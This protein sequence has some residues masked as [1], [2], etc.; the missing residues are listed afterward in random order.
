MKN[1][2]CLVVVLTLIVGLF[3][4]SCKKYEEDYGLM[5]KTPKGRL[6]GTWKI[7]Q[8][9]SDTIIKMSDFAMFG[10]LLMTFEKDESGNL[11]F[12]DN[13]LGDILSD[14]D[15]EELMSE[16]QDSTMNADSISEG[17]EN[18]DFSSMLSNGTDFKWAFD[19]KKEYIKLNFLDAT[20][21]S[22]S[23]DINMKILSLCKSD[24][25]LRYEEDS[26]R[27][28]ISMQK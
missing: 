9:E 5:L 26:T 17:L 24:C 1:R 3:F 15:W 11:K 18:I 2:I 12:K 22:Y 4:S 16:M 19:S 13:G 25:K 6:V 10:E 21:N 8:I 28:D 23:E 14:I 27:V 7:T 20:T